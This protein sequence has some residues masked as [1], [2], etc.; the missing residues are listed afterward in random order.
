MKKYPYSLASMTYGNLA[1]LL[2]KSLILAVVCVPGSTPQVYLSSLAGHFKPEC[3]IATSNAAMVAQSQ[4]L[5]A[6]SKHGSF[7]KPA[8]NIFVL[9]LANLHARKQYLTV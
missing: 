1:L 7:S 3:C 4:W 6:V 2:F 9:S 8:S 5:N